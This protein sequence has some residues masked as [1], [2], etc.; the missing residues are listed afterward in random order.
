M[1]SSP[2]ADGLRAQREA[3][4]AAAEKS[5]RG[6]VESRNALAGVATQPARTKETSRAGD[7]KRT[8]LVA[9][10]ATGPRETKPKRG[11]PL[12]KDADKTLAATQPWVAEGLSRTTWYRRQKEAK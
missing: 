11:R 4:A 9:G 12:A 2:K 6:G 7:N 8:H 1:K 10:V 5:S 3:R